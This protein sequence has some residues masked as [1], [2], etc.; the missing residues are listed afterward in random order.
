M[1]FE[2]DFMKGVMLF[3]KGV[4]FIGIIIIVFLFKSC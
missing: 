3:V 4:F 1:S 2:D